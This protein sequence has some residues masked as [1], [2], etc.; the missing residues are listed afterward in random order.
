MFGWAG[1]AKKGY[2]R[3]RE[4]GHLKMNTQGSTRGG[5][6]IDEDL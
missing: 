2:F 4:K 6:F 5:A 1:P 3:K